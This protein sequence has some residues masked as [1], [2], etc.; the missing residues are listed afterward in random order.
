MALAAVHM[1]ASPQ[2][3]SS[4]SGLSGG[5][6]EVNARHPA[7]IDLSITIAATIADPAATTV[8]ITRSSKLV[9]R[10]FGFL[11]GATLIPG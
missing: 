6:F 2:L 8:H 9:A 11:R 10:L 5:A 4:D 3:V 7:I 1:R